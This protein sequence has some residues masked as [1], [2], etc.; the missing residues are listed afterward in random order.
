MSTIK[1]WG[2]TLPLESDEGFASVLAALPEMVREAESRLEKPADVA[3]V[4]YIAF[5]FAL[6]L[7][8]MSSRG[9]R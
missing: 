5:G 8:A 7:L 3:A 9:A 6:C 2:E 4:R 1:T